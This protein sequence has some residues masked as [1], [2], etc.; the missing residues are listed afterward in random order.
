MRL[1]RQEKEGHFFVYTTE[2]SQNGVKDAPQIASNLKKKDLKN[3]SQLLSIK[4]R[5][6]ETKGIT[7]R[8]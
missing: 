5:K 6:K 3:G 8:D 7:Y 1:E 2:N 4:L